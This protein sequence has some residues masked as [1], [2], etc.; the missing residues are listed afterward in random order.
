VRHRKGQHKGRSVNGFRRIYARTKYG[1]TGSRFRQAFSKLVTTITN[2]GREGRA[3]QDET[4]KGDRWRYLP[5]LLL[6]IPLTAMI[7]VPSYN[8]TEPTLG[9]VPFFYWYQLAWILIGALLVLVV[10]LIE[11]EF[12]HR[13]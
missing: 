10:Y 4:P 11:G 1:I 5:R 2:G 9:D 6:L 7:C 12:T 13:T 3:M 8:R